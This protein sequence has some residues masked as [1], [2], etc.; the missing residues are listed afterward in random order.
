MSIYY[1]NA[2]PI[3]IPDG[4]TPDTG[5]HNLNTLLH[6][7]ELIPGDTVNF[8]DNGTIDDT[9]SNL[10]GVV[11]V[12]Y[13]SWSENVNKP[14]WR[15][16]PGGIF[17]GFNS[18]S[19]GN[20]DNT[21]STQF[22]D[23]N[24]VGTTQSYYVGSNI[25]FH[26]GLSPLIISRCTFNQTLV[27]AFATPS[28]FMTNCI[29]ISVIGQ[30]PYQTCVAI[31][32][33]TSMVVD[34]NNNTFYGGNSAILIYSSGYDSSKLQGV[35]LN[36]TFSGQ[37][38]SCISIFAI[39]DP[40]TNP[41]DSLLIDYSLTFNFAI[42][43]DGD[44]WS[45]DYLGSHNLSNIDPQLVD[46]AAGDFT[47]QATSPCINA[48]IGNNEKPFVPT[49]D[50]NNAVRNLDTPSIGAYESIAPAPPVPITPIP[51]TRNILTG[52]GLKDF[53]LGG[54]AG[55][56]SPYPGDPSGTTHDLCNEYF[57]LMLIDGVD[58]VRQKIKIRLQFFLGEWY[59]DTTV[60]TRYYEDVLVKN[61]PLSKLQ[62][63]FKAVIAETP[64]VTALTA[65]DLVFDVKNRSASI[66]FTA[67]TLYGTL[68]TQEI[69]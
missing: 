12:T 67:Q 2:N 42:E 48:G 47:L 22:Y 55:E 4:L 57:E 33:Q 39:G 20:S 6:T 45:T 61:P 40:P 21:T 36:N 8:V 18:L 43:F 63:L 24:I 13:K 7:L 51:I 69:L 64:G 37:N 5:F 60:G 23:L 26:P 66:T 54:I 46:P 16:C 15:L 25:D 38:T 59:L 52:K 31:Q 28:L 44:S 11:G 68:T 62:S 30:Q 32:T 34:I 41:I 35:F 9:A 29:F 50:Y 49:V 65:F 19:F 10:D 1:L 17:Y 58:Q 14:T 53:K 27:E 56:N 3:E